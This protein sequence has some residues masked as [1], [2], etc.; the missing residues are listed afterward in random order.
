[1][2]QSQ[3]F[4]KT[5]KFAPK[6][7]VSKNAQLLIRAGFVHKEMAGVY[8]FLPLGLRVIEKIKDII[9]EELSKVGSQEIKMTA[10]QKESVWQGT[11][12]WDDEVVDDWFKTKLKKGRELGL[13]FTHEEPIS[14]IMKNH[15]SSYKDLPIY[16]YQFQTKFRNELR[17]KSGIMRGRE[18][19]MK[20]LYDFSKNKEEH[21]QFYEKM[22]EVYM[23]IFKR[24]GIGGQTYLTLS[25]GGSFSKYSYE[26]QTLSTAGEDIVYIDKVTGECVNKDI[27]QGIADKKNLTEKKKELQKIEADRAV[28]ID[29][30]CQLYEC[31]PWQILKTVIYKTEKEKLVGVVIR[32]DLKINELLLSDLIIEKFHLAEDD[33]LEKASLTKGFISPVGGLKGIDQWIGDESIKTVRN[34][35]T[36]ANEFKKD[37]VNVNLERDFKIDKW[38]NFAVPT[39]DFKSLAGNKMDIKKSIEVGDIYTLEY[40]FSEQAGLTYKDEEGEEKLVFMGSYGIGIGR[41][42]GT[43]VEVLADDKG[44]VWPESV[45]PFKVHLIN[46]GEEKKAEEIYNQLQNAGVEVLWDDRDMRPGAKFADS[47][48]IGI[49][50]RIVVSSR[51]LKNGGV[52]FKKRIEKEG[53]VVGI[54]KI[55]DKL[56][57]LS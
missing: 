24:V 42:M 3:L 15:I 49:P 1:M 57:H 37:Y 53:N 48:L 36:G 31:E 11:N 23:N 18:F 10:L 21:S 35:N 2:R 39:K 9:K 51:S 41:L 25:P 33:D 56:K 26:F 12:R 27:V 8:S 13:A 29:A 16:V 45:A 47:D 7:E 52:E 4:T 50:N 34:Y 6:D 30:S 55:I 43:I 38:G 22:K 19:L 44:I 20:D 46:I 40:K 5:Q 54:E 17:A 28:N 14:F 32:G